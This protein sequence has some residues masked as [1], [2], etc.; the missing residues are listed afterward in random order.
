[1]SEEK[2]GFWDR[3]FFG[4]HGETER[5]R[6]VREYVIH[7]VGDGAHLRDVLQEEYVRRNASSDEIGHLLEN[8]ELIEAAHEQMHDEF[9]SG[10]LDPKAPPSSA[11]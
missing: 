1:M 5:E 2:Q 11:R 9:S 7:R 4:N 8:P 6:K 3:I 10:R